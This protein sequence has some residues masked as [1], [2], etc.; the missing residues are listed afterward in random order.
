M[1]ITRKKKIV[2]LVEDFTQGLDGITLTAGKEDSINF[3]ATRK[4]VWIIMEQMVIYLLIKNLLNLKEKILK[5]WQLHMSTKYFKRF[6][7]R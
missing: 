1:L 2:I 5:L 7:C 3:T 4:K 6:C